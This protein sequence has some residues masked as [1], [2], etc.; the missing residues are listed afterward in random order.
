M[1]YI[2]I[3]ENNNKETN[4]LIEM[5]Q[6]FHNHSFSFKYCFPFIGIVLNKILFKLENKYTINYKN[7]SSS[8]SGS[9]LEKN[10]FKGIVLYKKFGFKVE[11]I[12]T[13]SVHILSRIYAGSRVE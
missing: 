11:K 3:I 10:I 4:Y 2:N 9:F 1:K 7:L 12:V 5:D 6:Q 8:A 13:P